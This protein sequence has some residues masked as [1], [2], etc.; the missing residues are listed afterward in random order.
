MDMIIFIGQLIQNR[1]RIVTA[2][3]VGEN[4]FMLTVRGKDVFVK[5]M[6]FVVTRNYD[7]KNKSP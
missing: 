4:D 5:S 7:I 1:L 3:I 2:T 6:S